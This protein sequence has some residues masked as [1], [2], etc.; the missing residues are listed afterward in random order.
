L[1]EKV[2][3]NYKDSDYA[4][5]KFSAGIVYR[6]ADAVMEVSLADFLAE[7][8]GKTP[9]DFEALKKFSDNDYLDQARAENAQTN[10]NISFDKLEKILLCRASSPEE[11]IIDAPEKAERHRKRLTLVKHALDKLTE[12]QKR[13]YLLYVINGLTMREIGEQDGV[14][15]QSVDES[16]MAAEKKIKNVLANA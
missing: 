14:S 11:V 2:V 15:H 6:F 8:P 10:K 5:N 12:V 4:L 16:L 1:E 7:N 3:K 13:R 9:A